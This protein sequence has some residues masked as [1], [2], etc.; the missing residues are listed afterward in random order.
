MLVQ[1]KQANSDMYTFYIVEVL[2]HLASGM[3]GHKAGQYGHLISRQILKVLGI[4]TRVA[5]YSKKSSMTPLMPSPVYGTVQ[6]FTLCILNVFR[7]HG[8]NG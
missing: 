4:I 2:L 5:T 8:F 1:E 7:F 6:S 3:A